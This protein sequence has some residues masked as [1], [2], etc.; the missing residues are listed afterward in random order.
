MQTI[1]GK[2]GP[3][4]RDT[5]PLLA[6]AAAAVGGVGAVLAFSDSESPLR[7]PFA[8]FFLITMPATAIGSALS[9]MELP[10]R[11]VAST[12]GAVTI[13]LLIAQV[14]SAMNTGPIRAGIPAVA[15]VSALLFLP[16]LLRAHERRVKNTET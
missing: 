11:L 16:A 4:G 14:M 2:P 3:A 1:S 10:A 13:N 6:G 15:G 5:L 9:A 8:L 7:A 12:A